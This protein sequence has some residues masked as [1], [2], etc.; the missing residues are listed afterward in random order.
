MSEA[1]YRA[2]IKEMPAAER[3]RERLEVY[4]EGSLSTAELLAIALRTGTQSENAISLAG[5]LLTT[6]QGLEGL[7][8]ASVRELCRVPGIGP[9]KATQIKAAMELGRRLLLAQGDSRPQITSPGDA[10][11]YL[12]AMF[13]TQ[14]QE[15]LR[16]VLLD[17]QHRVL[18]ACLLYVGNVNSS[19]V[20][21]A[22]VFREAIKDNAPAILVAHNHPSGDPT[23]SPDDIEVTLAI[24]RAGK[25]LDISV[26]DHVIVGRS[27]HV[28]LKERGLGGL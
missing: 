25:L 24:A 15:Q 11:S 18:R 16:V 8:Q 22:E 5:R 6:F 13:G 10:A 4:G 3:P 20:R 23:P 7:S 21:V 17:T 26:L 19:M 1:E 12:R 14:P 27:G 28:S 2:I 9:A